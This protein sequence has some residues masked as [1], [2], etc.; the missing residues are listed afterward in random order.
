MLGM[1]DE[2]LPVLQS[3]P[4]GTLQL[5]VTAAASM[6]DIFVLTSPPPHFE[7]RFLYNPPTHF[8]VE[9]GLE[10]LTLLPPSPEYRILMVLY[11]VLGVEAGLHAC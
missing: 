8:I 11:T 6:H 4:E 3:L 9:D 7:A 2:S 10:L 1:N 5:P